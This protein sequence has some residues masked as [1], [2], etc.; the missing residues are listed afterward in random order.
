MYDYDINRKSINRKSA[1]IITTSKRKAADP[2]ESFSHGWQLSFLF[3]Q[4]VSGLIASF[5]FK[6]QRWNFLHQILHV[7]IQRTCKAKA[8]L[9][10]EFSAVPIEKSLLHCTSS[11]CGGS[12]KS[13][14]KPHWALSRYLVLFSDKYLSIFYFFIFFKIKIFFPSFKKASFSIFF[15][16]FK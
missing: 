12:F 6:I 1:V 4:S 15:L 13:L 8:I 11:H 14:K 5:L 10:E 3:A 16:L 9:P 2:W 7:A